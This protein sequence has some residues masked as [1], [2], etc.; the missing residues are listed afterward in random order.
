M[1]K[2]LSLLAAVLFSLGAASAV[3]KFN[4]SGEGAQAEPARP[5]VLQNRC[6]PAC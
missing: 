4:A 6:P 3:A 1:R 5:D 2:G